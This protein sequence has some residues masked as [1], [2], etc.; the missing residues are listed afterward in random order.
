MDLLKTRSLFGRYK[1]FLFP[2]VV[3]LAILI[4]PALICYDH[5]RVES[6]ALAKQKEKKKKKDHNPEIG[7]ASI[8]G[9]TFQGGIFEAS[10]VVAVPGANGALFVD[11]NR[12]NEI[13]WI[14]LDQEGNQVGEIKPIRI[15]VSV[16]DPEGITSDGSWF[17][18][19]SSHFLNRIEGSRSLVRFRFDPETKSVTNVESAVG[20]YQFLTSQIPELKEYAGKKGKRG[21]INIEGLAWDPIRERLL[22][23]LRDPAIMGQ[24]LVVALKL[25]DPNAPLSI[26]NLSIAEPYAILLSLDGST[27]RSIE[28]DEYENM[29]QIIS[30]EPE[31]NAGGKKTDFKLWE[32]DGRTYIREKEAFNPMLKPEGITRVSIGGR[33][34]IFIVCDVSRYF[35]ID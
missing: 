11:D 35:K 27:I 21:P 1:S 8:S 22:L 9:K 33:Y 30:G 6:A 28:F 16:D 2:T 31:N 5:I 24:A 7:P 18:V 12:A 19:V 13:F 15:G 20:L 25:Q 10:G 23:G 3:I 14:G 34:F 32:W 26:E 29:F 17:Y 4:G